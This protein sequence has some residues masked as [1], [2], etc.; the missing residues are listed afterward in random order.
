MVDKLTLGV[1]EEYL[2]VNPVTRNVM[3]NPPKGFFK[4]CKAAIG[5]RV[6]PEFLRCQ[7]EIATDICD[8]VADAKDQ[9]ANMRGEISRIAEDMGMALMAASTH[10][11]TPW[12]RQRPTEGER[13]EQLDNDMQGAIR[14]MMIC[15]MHVH[16]G[17]EN[18]EHRIDVQNQIRYFLPH[19][20]ALTTSSPFWESQPMGMKSYRLSVFD[21]MPRTGIPEAIDSFAEYQRLI[22]AIVMT[23]AIEDSSKIWWDIRPSAKFPTLEMRVCDVCTRLDDAMTVTAIYQSL[24][25]RLLRLKEDNMKWRVYPAFLISENRWMAQ[26]HGVTGDLIDFGSGKAVPYSEILEELIAWISEDADALGCLTE[27][28][29][30]RNILE[31]GSSACRQLATYEQARTAGLRKRDAFNAVVDMLVAETKMGF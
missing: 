26:R 3:G 18:P 7:I 30:A 16:V 12:K 19:M 4:A 14:R 25:R 27:V 5:E 2:L 10:P 15:G 24:T 17:L 6:T 28:E 23:G 1:E 29:N 9:I 11:F 8:T 31:R 22:D 13:Y 21:G 20:L